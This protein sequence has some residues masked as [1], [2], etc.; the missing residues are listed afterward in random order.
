MLDYGNES[1]WDSIALQ[2]PEGTWLA[3]VGNRL[4]RPYVDYYQWL[5]P[6]RKESRNHV[7]S[8]VEGLAKWMELKV[9]T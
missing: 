5:C 7:L 9:C 4:T 3:K 2:H 1:S 6:T 8:L